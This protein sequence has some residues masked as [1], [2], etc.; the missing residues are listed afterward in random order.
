V[1]FGAVGAMEQGLKGAAACVPNETAQ[2][3][4]GDP[5]RLLAAPQARRSS[6]AAV[7]RQALGLPMLNLRHV[8][9]TRSSFRRKPAFTGICARRRRADDPQG[10]GRRENVR[11]SIK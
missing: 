6:D 8:G 2:A 11:V 9:V 3:A 10:R 5:S 7:A 4:V 1:D